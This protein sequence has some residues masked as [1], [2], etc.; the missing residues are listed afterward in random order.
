MGRTIV[1]ELPE[2]WER[3]L[4]EA[5]TNNRH[6]CVGV[7]VAC[8]MFSAT[9]EAVEAGICASA[10]FKLK[11]AAGGGTSIRPTWPGRTPAELR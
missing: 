1:D 8:K 5:I 9:V 2:G 4:A 11:K 10:Y 6:K 7:S 3:R